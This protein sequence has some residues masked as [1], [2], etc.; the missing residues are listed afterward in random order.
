MTGGNI[1]IYPRNTKN[2]VERMKLLLNFSVNYIFTVTKN[3]S[4]KSPV[5]SPI[6]SDTF[7]YEYID[8]NGPVS[9]HDLLRLRDLMPQ[10]DF[11]KVKTAKEK[12]SANDKTKYDLVDLLEEAKVPVSL[13]L[14]V[15]L[16][17]RIEV[18]FA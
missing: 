10:E 3:T 9:K 13:D 1:E 4:K 8:L 6:S 14:L 5:P 16:E 7:L 12:L 2:K 17:K 15:N 11:E 18:C